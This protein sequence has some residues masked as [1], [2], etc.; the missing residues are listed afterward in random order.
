M[1]LP[2][3]RNLEVITSGGS[4]SVSGVNGGYEMVMGGKIVRFANGELTVNGVKRDV[5]NFATTL[6]LRLV[7]G[8]VTASGD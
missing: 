7:D 5:P 4:L 1:S 6:T 8:E 2:D 3:G